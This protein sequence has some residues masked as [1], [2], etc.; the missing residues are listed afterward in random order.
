MEEFIISETNKIFNKAIK[1]FAKKDGVEQE[2]V[3][4]LLSLGQDEDR[5]VVYRICHEFVPVKE[6]KIMDIL[7][8]LIDIKGYSLLVP[9]QI[10]KILENFESEQGSTDIEVGV[11]LDREDDEEIL[12]FLF[13]EGRLVSKFLLADVL[14]IEIE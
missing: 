2:N 12:Y 4:I 6:V 13:K 7:G 3:S 14:K 9:P 5:S 10:K 11:F 8:V 1:R